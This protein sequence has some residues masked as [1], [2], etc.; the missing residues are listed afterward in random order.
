MYMDAATVSL[1]KGVVDLRENRITASSL[2]VANGSFT[3]IAP[4]PEYV[5]EHPAPVDTSAP[6]PPMRILADS[7]ALDG[8][9]VVY[10]TKGA[11]PLPGFDASYISLSGVAV[12]MRNF[13]NEASTVNLP[14]TRL[15]ARERS[16]LYVT[17]GAGFVGVDSTGLTLRD[18]KVR[19]PY[20]DISGTAGIPFALME[21]NPKAPV[22]ATL[23]A[24]VGMP[25]VEAFMPALKTYTAML[26]NRNP[27][28][29]RLK[30]VGT[31][32]DVAIERLDARIDGFVRLAAKGYAKNALDLKKLRAGVDIDGEVANTS[33]I[34][35][36]LKGTG[37]HVPTF[38]IKGR[39]RNLQ[40]RSRAPYRR[41]FPRRPRAREHECREL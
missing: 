33:M 10:A 26:P 27:L 17:Q 34:S 23:A 2:G 36:M 3:Y 21:L 14:I 25:D 39:L 1:R 5:K 30:A 22:D 24:T 37:V 35:H 12:G 9:N 6:G 20:S 41:R 13:Y 38:S 29:A 4:T 8:F 31:L 15:T 7:I 32:A 40:S 18:L 19:T 11:K 16:G 28:V